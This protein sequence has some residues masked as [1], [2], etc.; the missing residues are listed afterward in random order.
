MSTPIFLP[1]I[2]SV[3]LH[4]GELAYCLGI[5]PYKLKKLI[6]QNEKTLARLGYSKHDKVLYPN[7]VSVL[8]GKS[9][10]QIDQ[11]KLAQC[12]GKNYMKV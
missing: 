4:K 3:S 8:L 2:V 5:S 11:E 10:L 6:Q 1:A 12:V 7:V 9:G